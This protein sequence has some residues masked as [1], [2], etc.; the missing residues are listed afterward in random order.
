[1]SCLHLL[2]G[3]ATG[4]VTVAPQRTTKAQRVTAVGPVWAQRMPLEVVRA[5]QG[6]LGGVPALAGACR[7]C[8]PQ[9]ACGRLNPVRPARLAKLE[10][11]A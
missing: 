7:L 1:M 4:I 10:P 9:A 3:T 2:D 5:L 11:S 6:V 8:L